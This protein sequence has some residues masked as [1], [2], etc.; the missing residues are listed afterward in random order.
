MSSITANLLPKPIGEAAIV[1]YQTSF[2]LVGGYNSNDGYIED[3]YQYDAAIDEWI[4][5]EA[6]LKTPRSH[7]VALLVQPSL[8]PDCP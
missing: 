6:K 1:P 7:H 8:F 4:E 3:I 5:L 2:L